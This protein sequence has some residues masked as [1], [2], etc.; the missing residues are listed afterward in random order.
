MKTIK[1]Y[2]IKKFIEG[3]D[4][5]G[6]KYITHGVYSGLAIIGGTKGILIFDDEGCGAKEDNIE[7]TYSIGMNDIPEKGV[8][9]A[10]AKYTITPTVKDL[11]GAEYKEIP[12]TEFISR[13]NT[14]PRIKENFKIILNT[15]NEIGLDS[16][17]YYTA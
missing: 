9:F 11:M 3:M 16:K 5:D 2:D 10:T 7:S 6:R 4:F 17:E 13:Y 8:M 12:I 1:V 15:I 14:K